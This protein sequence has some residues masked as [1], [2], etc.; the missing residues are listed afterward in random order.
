M[1]VDAKHFPKAAKI[2][3]TYLILRWNFEETASES[4]HMINAGEMSL[5]QSP[6]ISRAKDPCAGEM[7][8]Q[9]RLASLNYA[10]FNGAAKANRFL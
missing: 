7:S 2:L 8:K 1:P 5:S 6:P 9:G 10:N 3:S 4:F